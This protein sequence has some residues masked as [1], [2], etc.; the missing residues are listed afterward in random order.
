MITRI[1]KLRELGIGAIVT[2]AIVGFGLVASTSVIANGVM[3]QLH[4]G[5]PDGCTGSGLSP[6]C[7]KN[8][9]LTAIQFGDGSVKGK[10]TDR[11]A[12][13]DGFHADIDCL[14]V[15]EFGDVKVAWVSGIITKGTVNGG[16]FDLEG[17]PVW[18]AAVDI[19]TSAQ[20]A[21]RDALSFS[22]IGDPTPCTDMPEFPPIETFEGQVTIK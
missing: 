22:F 15:E 10:Y 17:F 8:F 2:A 18:T 13:V 7:D 6:G 14:H 21:P 20:D 1:L 5:G 12:G 16:T 3:H 19:G 11:F 9:S 4:V